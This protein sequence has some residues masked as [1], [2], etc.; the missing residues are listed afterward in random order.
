MLGVD[1][2]MT[3]RCRHY[4]VVGS[5]L[6]WPDDD[7]ENYERVSCAGQAKSARHN[8]SLVTFSY[9]IAR[10]DFQIKQVLTPQLDHLPWQVHRM[11]LQRSLTVR[12]C[13]A[14]GAYFSCWL[15]KCVR[16]GV[17]V[18]FRH[19][20]SLPSSPPDLWLRD[21]LT[22]GNEYNFILAGYLWTLISD[23][24]HIRTH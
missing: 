23:W 19:N 3:C 17:V 13:E 22:G 20:N 5:R 9:K 12:G 15:A 7:D 8:Y 6:S 21:S 24:K 1:L 2:N 11:S 14:S 10:E 16:S 4:P 18:T